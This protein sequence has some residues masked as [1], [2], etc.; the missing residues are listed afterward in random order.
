MI[1]T[2]IIK[3]KIKGEKKK[4]KSKKSKNMVFQGSNVLARIIVR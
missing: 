4:K 3:K 1:K 2:E